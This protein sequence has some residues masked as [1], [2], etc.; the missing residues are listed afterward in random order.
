MG[1]ARCYATLGIMPFI[2]Y[3]LNISYRL[4]LHATIVGLFK[5]IFAQC[6]I[7]TLTFHRTF[8]F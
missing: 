5:G 6:S 3:Q 1:N 7:N 8:A 4:P 2:L